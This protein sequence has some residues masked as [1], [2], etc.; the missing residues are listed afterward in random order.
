M[1]AEKDD[2]FRE[3]RRLPG[4]EGEGQQKG[5]AAVPINL[6]NSLGFAALVKWVSHEAII[7]IG[8]KDGTPASYGSFSVPLRFSPHTCGS[9]IFFFFFFGVFG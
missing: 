1:K 4:K 5:G 7:I 6:Q 3:K 2:E 8:Q 9:Y